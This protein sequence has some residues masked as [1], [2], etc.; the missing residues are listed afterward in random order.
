MLAGTLKNNLDTEEVEEEIA[1]ITGDNTDERA[2]ESSEQVAKDTRKEYHRKTIKQDCPT[3]WHSFL[4]VL[5]SLGSQRAPVVRFL[6]KSDSVLEWQLLENMVIFLKNF[7]SATEILSKDSEPTI[8][9]NLLFRSEL[10]SILQEKADDGSCLSKMKRN[11]RK[12]F[13]Y[14]FPVTDVQI[15]GA[16]LDPRFQNLKEVDLVLKD[17]CTTKSQFLSD[18]V[19]LYV[20]QTDLPTDYANACTTNSTL[21]TKSEDYILSLAAKHSLDGQSESLT[22]IERECN[23]FFSAFNPS[24]VKNGDV[25]GFW[26]TI[27]KQMPWL[28]FFC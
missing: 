6:K 24:P 12:N 4:I 7:R 3:R 19:R 9:L 20:L 11:M 8:N 13:D 17:R 23:S 25:L 1:K 16:L 28:S 5:E 26:K 14:R 27:S 18:Q 10:S 2:E 21:Q 15:A 22:A